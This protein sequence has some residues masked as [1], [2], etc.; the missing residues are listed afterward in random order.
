MREIASPA[1][2]SAPSSPLL[3]SPPAIK[4]CFAGGRG[5]LLRLFHFGLDAS[6]LAPMAPMQAQSHSLE[7]RILH[8]ESLRKQ[9]PRTSQAEWHPK[10]RNYKPLD[11]LLT[12]VRGRVAELLPIKWEMHT[13]I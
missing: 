4:F 9:M 2:L 8:G 10:Q 12:Q 1:E 11:L 3:Q 6:N 5:V 7:A 13:F